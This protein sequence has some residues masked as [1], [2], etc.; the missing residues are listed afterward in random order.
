M[1][2]RIAVLGIAVVALLSGCGADTSTASGPVSYGTDVM[3]AWSCD[4]LGGSNDEN[5]ARLGTYRCPTG[6]PSDQQFSE[7]IYDHDADAQAALPGL[8][9]S[10]KQAQLATCWFVYGRNWII[11]GRGSIDEVLSKVHGTQVSCAAGATESPAS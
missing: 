4:F 11:S 7:L 1:L 2:K 8:I 6:R 3:S 5:G 10:A 9:A